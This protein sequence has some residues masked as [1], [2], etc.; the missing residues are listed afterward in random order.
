[1]NEFD[2]AAPTGAM[3]SDEVDEA[4]LRIAVLRVRL[5]EVEPV[6][7]G[8]GGAEL[9]TRLSVLQDHLAAAIAEL[10]RLESYRATFQAL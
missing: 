7:E 1:M 10:E 6:P 5:A 3:V 2:W 8:Q 9:A 4:R